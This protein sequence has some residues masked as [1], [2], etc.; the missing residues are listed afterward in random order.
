MYIYLAKK[1][2]VNFDQLN[3]CQNIFFHR[4]SPISI[5]FYIWLRISKQLKV[6]NYCS[7]RY[8]TNENFCSKQKRKKRNFTTSSVS[9][10]DSF[11]DPGL[12]NH[13]PKVSDQF[14]TGELKPTAN[15]VLLTP[16]SIFL[17]LSLSLSLSLLYS[18]SL[19]SHTFLICAFHS[20][21]LTL[22]Y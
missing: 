8:G 7:P 20:L 15:Q 22:L 17:S 5:T 10:K 4:S 14:D 19:P 3:W 11:S 9:P 12:G 13:Q 21:S 1:P 18:L 6:R 16:Q 2:S